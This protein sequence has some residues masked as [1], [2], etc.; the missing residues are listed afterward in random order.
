MYAQ[1]GKYWGEVYLTAHVSRK[2]FK[3][4]LSGQLPQMTRSRFHSLH[5]CVLYI[6]C[7]I[8]RVGCLKNFMVIDIYRQHSICCPH[9]RHPRA[10]HLNFTLLSVLADERQTKCAIR[11]KFQGSSVDITHEMTYY[12]H[13]LDVGAIVHCS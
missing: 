4:C 6:S 9:Y 8:T 12:T 7:S 3:S 10:S 13:H 11:Y 5:R 2:W 1:T